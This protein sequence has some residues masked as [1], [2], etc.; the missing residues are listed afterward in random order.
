MTTPTV[1]VIKHRG[2]YDDAFYWERVDRNLGWLG[3]SDDEARGRQSALRD[4]VIGIAGAGG[5]GGSTTLRLIRMGVGTVKVA[6][7]D[8]FDTT[9]IQRQVGADLAHLGRNKA[10][11]IGEM[12]AEISGDVSIDVFPE[13]IT[14][15]TA[16][17]FVDGCDIVLDQIDVYAVDAHY[18]LHE[19]FRRSERCKAI[20]TVLTIGHAAYVFKYTKDS[21]Q[22]A[23]VYGIP[24]RSAD[25]LSEDELRQLIGRIIPEQPD[26]PSREAFDRWW[27]ENRTV[28]IWAGTPPLCEG[29]LAERAAL[30]L[31]DFPGTEPLP[32]QPGCAILDTKSWTSKTVSGA[33]WENPSHPRQD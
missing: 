11:V 12:G 24:K 26:F 18:S 25:D 5:I 31:M 33:W 6:D 20:I 23:D 9:N 28:S 17:P 22:I 29:V 4:S 32:V 14:D 10:A 8:E 2:A 16:Q 19:A 7:N 27:V 13:G 15:A 21:M 1:E 3:E 30:E